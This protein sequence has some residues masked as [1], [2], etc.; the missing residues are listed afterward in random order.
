MPEVPVAT[1]EWQE[2]KHCSHFLFGRQQQVF[3]TVIIY[4]LII[5]FTFCI[6]SLE[7][8]FKNKSNL[9]HFVTM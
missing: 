6:F 5:S 8:D 2:L 4:Y 7:T 9:Q 3:L 1:A